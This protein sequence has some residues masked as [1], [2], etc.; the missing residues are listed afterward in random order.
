MKKKL[1]L[2]F[3]LLEILVVVAV[4][5]IIAAIAYPSYTQHI[6]TSQRMGAQNTLQD[7]ISHAE[8]YY[9]QNNSTFPSDP[10]GTKNLQSVYTLTTAPTSPF[11]IYTLA[12]CT[13]ISNCVQA[14]AVTQGNQTR[15]TTCTTMTL[16]SNGVRRGFDNANTDTTAQCWTT[17]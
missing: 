14:S 11:Y 10:D 12:P 3:T 6:L 4:I 8:Q 2:G 1:S 9:V 13:G 17:K 16:D 7:I 15:D 5:G